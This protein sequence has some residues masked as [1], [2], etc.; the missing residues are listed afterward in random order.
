[1]RT[2][3]ESQVFPQRGA[4]PPLS[5]ILRDK[6]E[7]E[8]MRFV[9]HYQNHQVGGFHDG[10]YHKHLA[11]AA[12]DFDYRLNRLMRDHEM[13]LDNLEALD[14]LCRKFKER[15]EYHGLKG[16][17]RDDELMAFMVGAASALYLAGRK[18]EGDH[19]ASVTAMIFSTRGYAGVD[20]ILSPKKEAA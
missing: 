20:R 18:D 14:E 5:V 9:V 7:G 10:G 11:D 1:M 17:R 8:H 15:A 12:L 6:G 2:L 13:P 4:T 19:V 3:I 16:K